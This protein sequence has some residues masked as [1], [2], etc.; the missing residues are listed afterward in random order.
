MIVKVLS[1]GLFDDSGEN[2]VDIPLEN[3]SENQK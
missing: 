1:A 2:I 3:D